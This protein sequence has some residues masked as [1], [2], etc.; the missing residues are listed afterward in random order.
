MKYSVIIWLVLATL[1]VVAGLLLFVLAMVAK[2]WDFSQLSTVRLETR[3]HSFS[4]AFENI[5]IETDTAN[6]AFLPADGME[7]RVVCRQE[8]DG[9][10]SVTVE[11][12]T[13]VIREADARPWYQK[14]AFRLETPSVTVYLPREEYAGVTVLSNTGDVQIPQDFRFA[15]LEIRENTGNI[16][17]RASASQWMKLH[18]TTGN[19]R[20]ENVTAGELELSVSSGKVT[21]AQV[22]CQGNLSIRVSTG[23][24][25]LTDVCCKNLTSTGSTGDISLE[26]TVAEKMTIQ[27]DTGDIRF[28]RCDAAELEI[29]TDT[30]NVTGTLLTGKI[31]DARS[32]T[33]WV[34]VP[35]NGSGGTCRVRTDTGNIS[36]TLV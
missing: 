35:E 24:A 9:G 11:D 13:L 22:D 15:S 19:I 3:E 33:G 4:D 34:R 30:G 16:V 8:V 2:N 36:I 27:R 12:G 28:E 14:L 10:Y 31:F 6:I 7:T 17:C 5:R 1:L 32:D 18:T 20:L 29:T 25:R 21:V 23:N 26:N